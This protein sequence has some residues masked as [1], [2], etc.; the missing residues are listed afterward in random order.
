MSSELEREIKYLADRCTTLFFKR[1]SGEYVY[2]TQVL[3][4]EI[5]N[6]IELIEIRKKNLEKGDGRVTTNTP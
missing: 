2:L 5:K 4:T 3:F 6:L 1:G